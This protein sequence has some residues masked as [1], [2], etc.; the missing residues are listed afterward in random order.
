MRKTPGFAVDDAKQRELLA[1]LSG[2]IAIIRPNR[3]ATAAA[4]VDEML[5]RSDLLGR[6]LGLL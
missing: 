5:C 1:P 2:Q 3:Y 6:K 4:T